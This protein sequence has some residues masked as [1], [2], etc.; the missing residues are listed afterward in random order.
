MK[1]YEF[2]TWA[3]FDNFMARKRKKLKAD[4]EI[5]VREGL[6]AEP[7]IIAFKVII[8]YAEEEK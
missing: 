2:L 5:I 7:P 6:C 4:D 1:T 3:A 8:N